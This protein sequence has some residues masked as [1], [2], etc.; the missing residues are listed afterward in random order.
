MYEC[1]PCVCSAHEG[2]KRRV[3][4]PLEMELEMVISHQVDAELE[5]SARTTNALKL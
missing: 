1:A 2:Q 4:D 3:S 5:F